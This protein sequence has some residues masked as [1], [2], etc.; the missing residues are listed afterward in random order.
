[1]SVLPFPD[2]LS[3]LP[4][5]LVKGWDQL[6]TYR[7]SKGSTF[8]GRCPEGVPLGICL[9][10]SSFL[11]HYQACTL[12][13]FLGTLGSQ[14]P[15]ASWSGSSLGQRL[16]QPNSLAHPKPGRCALE[17]HVVIGQLSL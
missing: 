4:T 6:P 10:S 11:S 14:G 15:S 7:Q 8:E 9:M 5:L 16:V 2:H 12:G 3:R 17:L 1:M 13:I